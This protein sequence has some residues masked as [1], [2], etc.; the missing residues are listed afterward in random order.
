MMAGDQ[1][2]LTF[3]MEFIGLQNYTREVV[4]FAPLMPFVRAKIIK[5]N[6]RNAV[7]TLMNWEVYPESMHYALK[8]IGVYKGIKEIIVT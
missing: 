1:Q 5:A 6:E 8:R 2:K 4:K 7:A 3:K